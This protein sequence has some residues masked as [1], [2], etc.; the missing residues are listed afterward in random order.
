MNE[1][2]RWIIYKLFGKPPKIKPIVNDNQAKISFT[3]SI[4]SFL[5][6]ENPKDLTDNIYYT[7]T[8]NI[9]NFTELTTEE[10]EYIKTLPKENLIELIEIYNKYICTVISMK[11]IGDN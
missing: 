9:R 2:V 3:T 6:S 10:L 7:L 4:A 5:Y 8:K 1:I 11:Y